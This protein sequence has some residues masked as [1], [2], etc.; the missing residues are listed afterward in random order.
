MKKLLSIIMALSLIVTPTFASSVIDAK[1][2]SNPVDGEV[3]VELNDTEKAEFLDL[4]NRINETKTVIELKPTIEEGDPFPTITFGNYNQK[5]F[6][7]SKD[8]IEWY[9]LEK[10]D[11]KAILLSKYV[12][13]QTKY[14]SKTTET[15]WN[16]SSIRKWLND[17]FMNDA[18]T[19]TEKKFIITNPFKNVGYICLPSA[20]EMQNYFMRKD[21]YLDYVNATP[22]VAK[23]QKQTEGY[24]FAHW[25]Y[26]DELSSFASILA[27]RHG[28]V[29]EVSA[30]DTYGVRPV[31]LVK[32]IPNASTAAQNVSGQAVATQNANAGNAANAGVATQTA[33]MTAPLFVA[34]TNNVSQPYSFRDDDDNKRHCSM[35]IR[36]PIFG[37]ANQ[38][39]A[40]IMNALMEPEGR[41]IVE[42]CCRLHVDE[43]QEKTLNVTY[44]EIIEQDSYTYI[45]PFT[46]NGMPIC[47]LWFNVATRQCY[48]E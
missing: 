12:L 41:K 27:N 7:T 2:K 25:L 29:T 23:K 20:S 13:D 9:I 11:D 3:A 4:S 6:S 32:F 19:K 38:D 8:P 26:K 14:N 22:K 34:N 30:K 28:D 17:T 18:F 40:N 43:Y 5:S 48:A 24:A 37:S 46:T 47:R 31:I 39:K 45:V 21:V 36:I 42:D 33:D 1:S 16:Q 35:S 44:G 10:R 15:N